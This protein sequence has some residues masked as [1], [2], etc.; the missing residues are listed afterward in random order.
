MPQIQVF[1]LALP[2]QILLSIVTLALVVSAGLMFWLAKF[3]EGMIFFL[4]GG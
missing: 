4:S 1:L 2:L 3:E